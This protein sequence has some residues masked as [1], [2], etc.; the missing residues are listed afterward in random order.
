MKMNEKIKQLQNN[1]PIGVFDSGIGGLSVLHELELLLPA[2]D[3][4]Y[5]GDSANIPYGEKSVEELIKFS[6]NILDYFATQ[7]VKMVVMA[8]NTSSSVTLD[9]V[10]NEYD[11]EIVG[12]LEPISQY[13]ACLDVQNIGIMGTSATIK[14]NA[15]KDKICEYSNKNVFQLACPG[16]VELV[17]NDLVNTKKANDLVKSYVEPLLQH[18]IQRLILG[19]THYP[20]LRDV[21]LSFIKEDILLNPAVYLSK[22][23][24]DFLKGNNLLAENKKGSAKFF[25]SGDMEDFVSVGSKF[26]GKSFVA[27]CLELNKR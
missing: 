14:S 15:Y 10:K 11:F 4:I 8:C 7:N 5:F 6:R 19:C 24:Y 9:V 17:E 21:I 13:L 3:F 27:E 16:L 18:D 2:E 22:A 20:F 26:Y 25:C 1:A 23:V 12:L